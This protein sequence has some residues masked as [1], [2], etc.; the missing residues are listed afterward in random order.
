MER[1]FT[2]LG[3]NCCMRRAACSGI[4]FMSER[5][6]GIEMEFWWPEL[7]NTS[8]FRCN[9][10]RRGSCRCPIDREGT[11]LWRRRGCISCTAK[12]RKRLS[13][14]STTVCHSWLMAMDSPCVRERKKPSRVSETVG[15]WRSC[16]SLTASVAAAPRT[17]KWA[18]SQ[19]FHSFFVQILI[20]FRFIGIPA[21]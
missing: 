14:S 9:C 21:L 11:L 13:G 4:Y 5:W 20:F 2:T 16:W 18:F 15:G 19:R 6:Q 8:T 7:L 1:C 17:P 10:A 12:R 3:I